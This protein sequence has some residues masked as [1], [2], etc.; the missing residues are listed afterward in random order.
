MEKKYDARFKIVCEAIKRLLTPDPQDANKDWL[1]R[2]TILK[3][4]P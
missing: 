1:C 3:L 2:V 4:I